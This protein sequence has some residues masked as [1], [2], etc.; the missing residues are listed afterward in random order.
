MRGIVARIHSFVDPVL[1]A[2]AVVCGES[3]LGYTLY[4]RQSL[5]F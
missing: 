2:R 1:I 4:C 3:S 5:C